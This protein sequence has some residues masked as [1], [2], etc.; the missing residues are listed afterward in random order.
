[1]LNLVVLTVFLACGA[2]PAEES[3]ADGSSMAE[4][5]RR[6]AAAV[7]AEP[8]P[9]GM[10]ERLARESEKRTEVAVE[11]DSAAC[12]EAKR[13]R[14]K[15]KRRTNR[16]Y[17][18]KVQPAEDKAYRAQ[19]ALD[20]CIKDLGGCGADPNRYKS[21]AAKRDAAERALERELEGVGELEARLFP[22]NREVARACGTSR[23]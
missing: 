20:A 6:A 19:L 1:M 18:D 17:T 23:Y 14:D 13:S 4:S 22:L 12:A 10:P 21:V 8:D 3:P 7:P 9:S 2:E 5:L 15:V 11:P 16:V